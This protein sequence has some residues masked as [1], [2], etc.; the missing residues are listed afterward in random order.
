ML[1]KQWLALGF[2]LSAILSSC[3][4]VSSRPTIF[5]NGVIVDQL[6]TP[7]ITA[8]EAFTIP[9]NESMMDGL[10]NLSLPFLVYVGNP[11]CS[12]CIQFQP[13]LRA[14]I[15]DEQPVVY[16][17]NTL[18]LIY[19][20]SRF[21]TLFPEQFSEPFSTPSLYLFKGNQRLFLQ[22]SQPAFY[23]AGRF[24]SLIGSLVQVGIHRDDSAK[25]W[26][27]HQPMVVLWVDWETL[28]RIFFAD[29]LDFFP[30]RR[31]HLIYGVASI[32]LPLE[33]V[34]SSIDINW[35]PN[36]LIL[37]QNSP[38]WVFLNTLTTTDDFGLWLSEN[39]L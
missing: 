36:I 26:Q 2:V 17:L 16:Y 32:P 23:S 8:I 30:D 27:W 1:K 37:W 7:S 34:P 5:R 39:A 10:L 20:P 6:N 9:L 12:S 13:Y 18:T 22:R 11:S 4:A 24:K 15:L 31:V 33:S 14:W 3:Q 25:T 35:Q 28:P 19:E 29:W 21:Q 38:K